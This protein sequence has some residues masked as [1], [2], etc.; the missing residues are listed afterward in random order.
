MDSL[1]WL[2]SYWCPECN[3]EHWVNC[4]ELTEYIAKL[5][6]EKNSGAQQLPDIL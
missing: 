3:I 2:F 5:H 4:V 6:A 1:T